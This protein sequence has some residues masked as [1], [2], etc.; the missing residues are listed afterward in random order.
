MMV[1]H[2]ESRGHQ[3]R[4]V[5]YGKGYRDLSSKFKVFETEGLTIKTIDN[6]VS[7]LKTFT[8]NLARLAP[9]QKK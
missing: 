1:S 4:V 3:V 8:E 9:G 2:L 7:V 5:S 6:A